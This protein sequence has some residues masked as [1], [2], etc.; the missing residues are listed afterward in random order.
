MGLATI[1]DFHHIPGGSL[2]IWELTDACSDLL[3]NF[4]FTQKE[5]KEFEKIKNEKRKK[6]Y[7]SVRLL[8][9]SML[10]DRTE[11]Y[12]DVSGKPSLPNGPIHLSIAHSQ[13]VAVILL[14]GVNAGVDVETISRDTGKIAS[15]YLS[16]SELQDIKDSS[17]AQINRII[18]W[19]AKEA[20]YKFACPDKP[21]FKSQII[22]Q[23]FHLNLQGG[24]F[25]GA[26][27]KSNML[28]NLSFNYSFYKNNVIVSCFEAIDH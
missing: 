1:M 2:G 16:E 10:Q 9:D 13:E 25:K 22:I 4:N 8:L 18:Y 24:I 27:L 7:L 26:I 3:Q 14:S 17:D 20:A 28:M 11:I 23:P 6:E 5:I 19:S 15:R 12:Y 21:E